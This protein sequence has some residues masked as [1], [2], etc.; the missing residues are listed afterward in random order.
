MTSN[1]AGVKEAATSTGA[2]ATQVL[3]A[4]SDLSRQSEALTH[5]VDQFL[6]GVK[7]A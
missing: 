1:I 7:A 2:A 3:G 6:A 5:E 4:A